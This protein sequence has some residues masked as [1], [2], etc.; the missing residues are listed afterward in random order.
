MQI[1]RGLQAFGMIV[2]AVIGTAGTSA[3]AAQ[4]TGTATYRERML[5]PPGALFEATL[6]D[7]S[8]AD[9]RAGVI[10]RARIE[11]PGPPP[12]RFA[13]EYDPALVQAGHHYVVRARTDAC[14]HAAASG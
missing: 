4:V 8:R 5:L 14:R 11:S 6:E 9:A 3:F 13:I 1:Q 12:F 10:G 2:A 7:V